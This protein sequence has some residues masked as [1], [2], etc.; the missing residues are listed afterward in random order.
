MVTTTLQAQELLAH[1]ERFPAML[2]GD[3]MHAWATLFSTMGLT[4][5]LVILVGLLL[6]A[7]VIASIMV[8]TL[9]I[10]F[11]KTRIG[12]ALRAVADSHKAARS[13]NASGPS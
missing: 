8:A 13:A 2:D 3:A 11:Q 10:F 1:R 5:L 6:A 4:A 9:A 12:R 7:A